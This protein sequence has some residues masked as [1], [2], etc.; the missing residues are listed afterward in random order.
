MKTKQKYSTLKNLAIGVP[1]A[2]AVMTGY[3]NAEVK[4]YKGLF[5]SNTS[6]ATNTGT[7]TSTSTAKAVEN[8]YL[9]KTNKYCSDK[10]NESGEISKNIEAI[11]NG[12]YTKPNLN[13]GDVDSAIM[14]LEAC[15]VNYNELIK[16]IEGEKENCFAKS[17]GLQAILSTLESNKEYSSENGIKKVRDD[18]TVYDKAYGQLDATSNDLKIKT[19]VKKEFVKNAKEN[20]N[21]LKSYNRE[22]VNVETAQ[23]NVGP[24]ASYIDAEKVKKF[25]I[26]GDA[27]L[28]WFGIERVAAGIMIGKGDPGE[29]ITDSFRDIGGGFKYIG[30]EKSSKDITTWDAYID[31][32]IGLPDRNFSIVIGGG[33]NRTQGI[34]K[35][36]ST[37]D[38]YKNNVKVSG[39]T[40]KEHSET[41][42]DEYRGALRVGVYADVFGA[43]VKAMYVKEKALNS[44]NYYD[45]INASIGI[46]IFG[47]QNGGEKK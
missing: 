27:Y 20:L 23:L 39:G 6:K 17:K 28:G 35:Y 33:L 42:A 11:L 19:K 24:T 12:T 37:L 25:G 29:T 4:Q 14:R 31:D 47:P 3:A 36:I 44:D 22:I 8:D 18:K 16:G 15:L 41:L 26:E 40:P 10:L 7:S 13:D 9:I 43:K 21:K 45:S 5:D 32:V 34:K 38:L 1:L 2:L 46:P 30:Q